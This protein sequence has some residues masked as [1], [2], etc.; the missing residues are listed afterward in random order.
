MKELE[1]MKPSELI[2][3][4]MYDLGLAEEHPEYRVCMNEWHEMSYDVCA[5]CFAGAVMAFSLGGRWGA[6]LSPK[7]FS[8]DGTPTRT[9]DYL[10]ALDHFRCGRV[11]E[12]LQAM[13]EGIL[14]IQDVD[15]YEY[16]EDAGRFREDMTGLIVRLE[17]AGL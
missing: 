5:V 12:G 17:R 10:R 13:G 4:A 3:T 9:T 15:V 2:R 6:P 14:R 8:V 16:S 7:S 1:K 11:M